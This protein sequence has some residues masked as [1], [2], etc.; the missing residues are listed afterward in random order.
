M[1]FWKGTKD[2]TKFYRT[3]ESY[4]GGNYLKDLLARGDN[5]NYPQRQ[6]ADLTGGE[7]DSV[8]KMRDLLANG[9]QGYN[10]AMA[11][12]QKT[13]NDD[14]DPRTSDYYQGFRNEMEDLRGSSNNAIRLRSQR[15]GMLNSS[16]SQNIEAENNRQINDQ[17]TTKLGSLYE[18]ERN[19][20]SDAVRTAAGL[21]QQEISNINQAQ[22][23]LEKPRA[24]E[25][26]Y[27]DALYQENLQELLAPYEVV[28][29][30]ALG[31]YNG[32]GGVNQ[33]VSKGGPSDL[34]TVANV[35]AWG[36]PGLA[37]A[38]ANGTYM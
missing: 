32:S 25:Q 13:L 34:T 24:I 37:S 23:V 11:E 22:G 31:M 12:T 3:A 27:Y 28:A 8:A 26:S 7:Q 6:V 19:R 14:Y 15:G 38:A 10:M 2:K 33:Y 4:A 9:T 30:V 16:P 35:A 36:A 20:K 21:G 29:N 17:I 5:L 18:N 1:S